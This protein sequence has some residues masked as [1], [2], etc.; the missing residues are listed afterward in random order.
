MTKENRTW[1]YRRIQ[2]ALVNLGH[3]IDKSTVCNILRRLRMDP[4][5]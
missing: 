1:D 4:A 2:G 3:L 5:P